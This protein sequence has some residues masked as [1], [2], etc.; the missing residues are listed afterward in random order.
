MNSVDP[1][2]FL[3]VSAAI[4]KKNLGNLCFEI[5]PELLKTFTH[6]LLIQNFISFWVQFVI[7][8]YNFKLYFIDIILPE[9]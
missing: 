6:V 2:L 1:I 9:K 8:C 3:V 5:K 4:W 7:V